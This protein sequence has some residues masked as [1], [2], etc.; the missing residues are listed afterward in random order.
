MDKRDILVDS[1]IWKTSTDPAAQCARCWLGM[2]ELER[3]T[4]WAGREEI[5]SVK[6]K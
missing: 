5:H 4:T 6:G 3:D 2:K 1:C